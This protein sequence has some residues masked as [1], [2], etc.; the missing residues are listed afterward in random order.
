MIIIRVIKR[1]RQQNKKDC[2][3]KLMVLVPI[4][5]QAGINFQ[6]EQLVSVPVSCVRQ[7][8]AVN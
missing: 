4:F 2:E 6:T 8:A 3:L 1:K 5:S 7:K